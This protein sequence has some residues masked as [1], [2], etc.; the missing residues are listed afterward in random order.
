MLVLV[1]VLV[2]A[3]LAG[4]VLFWSG[5]VVDDYYGAIAAGVA[6]FVLVG[7]VAD[8]LTKERGTLRVVSRAT[9]LTCSALAVAGFWWT[10]IRE[11]EVNEDIVTGVAAS[12]LAQQPGE[13][14]EDPEVAAALDEVAAEQ[15]AL[16]AEAGE[17]VPEAAPAPDP[18]PVQI[19]DGDV[20]AVGHSAEGVAAVVRLPDGGKVLT[21]ADGFDIDPGPQVRVYLVPTGNGDGDTTGHVDLGEL[22]GSKGNQQYEIPDDVDVFRHQKVIFWCVPFTQSLAVA[23]LEAS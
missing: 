1:P 14:A 3:A 2:V 21:L 7:A 8:K 11:T 16:A 20:R 15:A 17:T 22:K 5:V 9:V 18:D 13:L 19:L 6:W 23:D 10:S 12:E 4:G